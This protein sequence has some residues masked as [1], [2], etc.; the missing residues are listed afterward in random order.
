MLRCLTLS[1]CLCVGIIV[2]CSP[3]SDASDGSKETLTSGPGPSL[4]LLDSLVLQESDSLYIGKPEVGLTVD[5][6]GMIYVADEFWNR[7]VRFRRNGTADRVFGRAGSGPGEFRSL[8][9]AT[10]VHDSLVIQPTSAKLKVFN[11]FTGEFLLERRVQQRVMDQALID[12]G[13]LLIASFDF[14]SKRGLKVIPLKQFLNSDSSQ[15]S[16]ELA[17]TLV[18]QPPEFIAYPGLLSTAGTTVAAWSDTLLVGYMGVGYVVR[19]SR[20]GQPLDTIVLPVRMR[21]GA[22]AKGREVYA[23]GVKY[24]FPAQVRS[25]SLLLRL[26]QLPNG[27]FLLWHED[28]T[29]VMR[30]GNF[31]LS[32]IAYISILARDGRTACVDA[33][34]PFPG[35]DWPRLTMHGD[36]LYALDQT[37]AGVDSTRAQTVVRRYLVST[38]RCSWLKT[39]ATP[40]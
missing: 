1:L 29:A 24:D 35:S 31:L 17:S 2:A 25:L 23:R 40:P 34:L 14:V 4:T 32:G 13:D 11:R 36:T 19:Y 5:D 22:S 18:E 10:V 33:R 12:Q 15:V 8:T 9:A 37:A 27:S 16:T 6:S 26:W 20:S 21:R 3:G 39:T 7:L 38:D 30:G 28:N